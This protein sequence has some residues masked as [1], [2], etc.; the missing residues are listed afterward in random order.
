MPLCDVVSNTVVA[1]SKEYN[2]FHVMLLFAK[3]SAKYIKINRLLYAFGMLLSPTS[4]RSPSFNKQ[5]ELLFNVRDNIQFV[6]KR[7][8]YRYQRA[9]LN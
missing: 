9:V 1:R 3:H 8:F 7:Q 2:L 4:C 5:T 6:E